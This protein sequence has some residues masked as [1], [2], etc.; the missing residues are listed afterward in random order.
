MAHAFPLAARP[1]NGLYKASAALSILL[2]LAG[3]LR[4][5]APASVVGYG[6][7]RNAVNTAVF[8]KNSLATFKNEQFTAFYDSAGYL[9]LAKRTLPRGPWQVQKTAY[10]GHVEDAHNDISLMVDG[11]GYLHIAYDHHNNRLHYN[12]GLRPGALALGP[13]LPMTGQQ[14]DKVSDPEFHRF[15]SGD[16]AFLYREGGSGNGNLVMNRYDVKNQRWTRL[17]TVLID[18][19]GQRNAYWQAAVDEQGTFHISWVWRETPDVATNHDLAYARSRDGGR[20]RQKSTGEA[21][22]LP[23]TEATAEYA[24]RIPQKSELINQTSMCG[25]AQGRPYIATY[26]R[27][28]G[29]AAV[30][31]PAGVPRRQALAGQPSVAAHP[32]PFSL[33]GGGTEKIPIARPQVLV[34]TLAGKTAVYVVFRDAERG[35]KASLATCPDLARPQWAV[36]DFPTAG[37]GNWEP[38]YDTERW[39][40]TKVLNLFIQRTGQ[41]DGETLEGLPPAR[42]GAGVD[43]VSAASRR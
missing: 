21:Y 28:A 32:T 36:Q 24:L 37:L 2:L 15:P 25:D 23:I 13:M 22:Q 4:A 16:L 41:G 10:R 38:T 3:P 19:Q 27:P 30:P 14:E 12:R 11:A 39:K 26:W 8:R 43:A 31:V 1:L 42:I 17:H 35:D 6:W 33:S 5:Q 29:R 34:R 9:V 18:G 20:T 40:Q 7:A